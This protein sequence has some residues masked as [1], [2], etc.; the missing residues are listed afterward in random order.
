MKRKQWTPEGSEPT[1]PD[2]VKLLE[3][4]MKQRKLRAVDLAAD[5]GISKSLLSDILAYRRALSKNVIRKLA[6]RFEVDQELFNRPYTLTTPQQKIDKPAGRTGQPQKGPPPKK[7]PRD[8]AILEL[9]QRRTGMA[10]IAKM[11]NGSSIMIWNIM[12]S[13]DFI[14]A[15]YA[16][17]MTN[18]TP[19][20]KG[21][22]TDVCS[23]SDI[24]KLIDPVTGNSIY[25][26]APQ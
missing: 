9:L 11:K 17:I 19:S 6:A 18:V 16:H 23:T 14:G 5:L 20:I 25:P 12:Y 13:Y 8:T 1:G 15:G 22:K 2:P 3:N 7:G 4:L 26:P 21:E 24:V 10:T